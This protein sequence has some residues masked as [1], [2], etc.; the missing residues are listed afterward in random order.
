MLELVA[1]ILLAIFTVLAAGFGVGKMVDEK[2][3]KKKEKVYAALNESSAL[4]TIAKAA[5]TGYR[6]KGALDTLKRAKADY[7]AI[8]E[9]A[10]L[11][12]LIDSKYGGQLTDQYSDIDWSKGGSLETVY[13]ALTGKK[14][15]DD[16]IHRAYELARKGKFSAENYRAIA[17]DFRG[18]R[19]LDDVKIIPV[20]KILDGA[21]NELKEKAG[22]ADLDKRTI[23]YKTKGRSRI[24]RLYTVLHEQTEM[25]M[26]DD[27]QKNR[28]AVSQE[29][30]DASVEAK[31]YSDIKSLAGLQ[32]AGVHTARPEGIYHA[33]QGYQEEYWQKL[34]KKNP[35]LVKKI[36]SK[37]GKTPQYAVVRRKPFAS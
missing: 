23:E 10:A 11:Q 8:D 4:K 5:A 30:I 25:Q 20:E 12:Y 3:A 28:K 19:G 13:K 22:K 16:K 17:R 18:Y 6:I 33:L 35:D 37:T 27:L 1:M 34:E 14:D 7:R 29:D 32:E 2:I 21:G 31:L 15:T 9:G 24:Q 36:K 26:L